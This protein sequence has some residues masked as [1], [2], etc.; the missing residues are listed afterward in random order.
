MKRKHLIL[1]TVMA[2]VL[3]LLVSA[4]G[5]DPTVAPRATATARPDATATP[6]VVL[7]PTP[8]LRPGQAT[9]TPVPVVIVPPI[10]TPVVLPGFEGEWAR[11]I[12]AAQEEG[13]LVIAGG[14]GVAPMEPI[15]ELFTEKYGIKVTLGRGSS[16]EHAERILAEQSAG[17]FTVDVAHSG[18][19]S[20]NTRYIGN[21]MTQP[22]TPFIFHPEA[23][24]DQWFGG[25]WWFT[26]VA[27]ESHFVMTSSLE[28]PAGANWWWNTNNVSLETVKAF[29]DQLDVLGDDYIGRVISLTH[30]TGGSTG[31][32]LKQLLD[33]NAGLPY[34]YRLY[35]SAFDATFTESFDQIV[36]GLSFGAYDFGVDIGSAGT[37]LEGIR[38]AGGPVENYGD[39]YDRGAV[40][41]LPVVQTINATG[42]ASGMLLLMKNMPNPNA[43]KLYVNWVLTTEGQQAI[44]DNV[45]PTDAPGQLHARVS[46]HRGIEPG[47]TLPN[48]QWIDGQTYANVDMQ[49]DLRPLNDLVYQW[50]RELES[51]GE[52]VPP[53]FDPADYVDRIN[54]E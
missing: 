33:P 35:S 9:P 14:G 26:D 11:L 54:L 4:C 25:R 47:L 15:Y 43:T 1:T 38:D 7:I 40:D 8:T 31:G 28:S 49:P 22:I 39:A 10:P 12:E 41:E 17:R 48:R 27:G 34:Y 32:D 50:I 53:P 23:M 36:D 42:G 6:T 19:N 30:F 18:A 20:A 24:P 21:G 52:E 13:K 45:A 44:Q 29:D 16:R 3:G 37:E 46:L 51:T 2:T 5:S